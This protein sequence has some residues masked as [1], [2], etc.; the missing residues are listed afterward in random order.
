M[1]KNVEKMQFPD[2]DNSGEILYNDD[3]IKEKRKATF[4]EG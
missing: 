2:I 4:K 3:E 1:T